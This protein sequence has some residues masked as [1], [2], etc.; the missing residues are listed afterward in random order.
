MKGSTVRLTIQ[1]KQFSAVT[2][3]MF[4]PWDDVAFVAG[5]DDGEDMLN[6]V[7]L[8]KPLLNK[9]GLTNPV[10]ESNKHRTN[11]QCIQLISL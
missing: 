11:S 7:S 1:Y 6:I 3:T 5:D 9:E 10:Y 2:C 4:F 8:T